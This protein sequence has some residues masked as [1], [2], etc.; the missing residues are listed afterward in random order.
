MTIKPKLFFFKNKAL[1][2]FSTFLSAL[3]L[4]LF[5]VK[6]KAQS[7]SSFTFTAAGDYSSNSTRTTAV[8]NGMNPASSGANFNLALGDLSY[9]SKT[10]ETAWCDYVKSKVGDAFPFEL[11]PGNHEDDGPAGNNIDN[12]ELCLPD[13]IGG[14]AGRYSREYYFDY[15]IASPFARFIAISPQMIF[16]DEGQYT[17]TPGNAHFV[18]VE[19]AID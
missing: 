13:R 3:V 7:E 16:L 10:P 9:G 11:I 14:I 8:L 1:L 5:I 19:N 15:P 12:F 4:S 17:Y 18:W 6:T 2:L